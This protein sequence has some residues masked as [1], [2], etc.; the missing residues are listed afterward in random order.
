[1]N[2]KVSNSEMTWN[3]SGSSL[4]LI[5]KGVSYSLV[6][7]LYNPPLVNAIQHYRWPLTSLETLEH[8]SVGALCSE[9]KNEDHA[10]FEVSSE[11]FQSLFFSLFIVK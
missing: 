6:M 7:R 3:S 8:N 10:M 1:M 5:L 2:A 9:V 11:E 4:Y